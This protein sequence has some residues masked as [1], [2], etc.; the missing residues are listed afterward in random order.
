[1]TRHKLQIGRNKILTSPFL[2][3][4][5]I[6]DRPGTGEGSKKV[7]FDVTVVFFVEYPCYFIVVQLPS[8][9]YSDRFVQCRRFTKEFTGKFFGENNRIWLNQRRFRI[10]FFQLVSKYIKKR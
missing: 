9:T 1:M 3:I 7:C 8:L 6:F 4:K 10:S 2:F 5:N